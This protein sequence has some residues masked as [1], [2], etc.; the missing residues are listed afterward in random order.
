MSRDRRPPV[1]ARGP[2]RR[3]R[4]L[5]ATVILLAAALPSVA[6]GA[7]GEPATPTDLTAV[8]AN[9]TA[10]ISFTIPDQGGSALTDVQYRVDSASDADWRSF[11]WLNESLAGR[12]SF[13]HTVD[14][15]AD[16]VAQVIDLRAVNDEGPSGSASITVTP[17]ATSSD[18]TIGEDFW[19]AFLDNA[20]N[21]GVARISVFVAVTQDTTVTIM[22]SQLSAPI[23]RTVTTA[24]GIAEINLAEDLAVIPLRARKF[25]DGGS[26]TESIE[27]RAFRIVADRPIAAYALNQTNSTTDAYVL[28]PTNGLGERYRAASLW[29]IGSVSDDAAAVVIAAVRNDTEVII[30]DIPV[31]GGGT[32]ELSVTLQAGET[33]S[34]REPGLRDLDDPRLRNMSGRLITADRPIAVFSGNERTRHP[35]VR[36]VP[37]VLLAGEE[38]LVAPSPVGATDHAVSQ[39]APTSAWGTEFVTVR[40]PRNETQGD[41][42]LIVADVAGTEVVIDGVTATTLDAGEFEVFRVLPKPSG[43][44]FA[45]GVIQ[46]SQPAQ[47]VQYLLQGAYFGF[48]NTGDP[49][50]ALVVPSEQYLRDYSLT[51]VSSVFDF[52][53][54]NVVIPTAQVPSFRVNGSAPGGDGLIAG[55]V[56]GATFTPIGTTRFSGAQIRLLDATLAY[57]FTADVGFGVFL[58]GGRSNDGYATPGGFAIRDLEAVRTVGGST[59]PAAGPAVVCALDPTSA[60]SAVSCVVTGGDPGIEIL[61]RATADAVV[62]AEAG[63]A[64][65]STG[66]G[67]FAFLARGV[68]IGTTVDVELVE[69][70]ASDSLALTGCVPTGIPAGEGGSPRADVVAALALLGLTVA[71]LRQRGRRTV[72]GRAG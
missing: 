58:Y 66:S 35:S 5:A 27:G 25:T 49:S 13:V 9:G 62:L 53:G 32:T 40:Y 24:E 8:A 45:G 37:P 60:C 57:R 54:V 70:A 56:S 21:N 6:V 61:W 17:R 65:D 28:I 71:S 22:G 47:V 15:L 34:Y 72:R 50:M 59:A 16:G 38:V 36:E 3:G 30:S 11:G 67:S 19:V 2:S 52:H 46:T 42:V 1:S 63:V 41:L 39:L 55:V 64:L 18:G 44:T 33:F 20:L 26:R 4:L 69:W 68:P 12:T 14:D 51:P 7:G 29:S 48:S 31:P 23:T 43:G 10:T